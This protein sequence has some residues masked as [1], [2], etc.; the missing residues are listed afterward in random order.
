MLPV[1]VGGDDVTF[2]CWAD[3]AL[4]L[5]AAFIRAFEEQTALKQ[6]IVD[7]VGAVS[8]AGAA[9]GRGLTAAA[10]IAYVK[11][12][13]PFSASY[14]LAEELTASA[15]RVNAAGRR[16]VSALDFHVTFES[17]LADLEVLRAPLAGIELPRHGGPYVVD[18]SP[19]V[20]RTRP[21]PALEGGRRRPRAAFV[22]GP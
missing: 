4:D 8:P 6:T 5:T 17:T 3:V 13:H 22:P 12:H 14:A 2:A 19:D 11:P 9:A 16:Q 18:D 7:V 20:R 10:G 15:K 21:R 1:V